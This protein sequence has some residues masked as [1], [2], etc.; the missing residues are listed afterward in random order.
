[1]GIGLLVVPQ[2]FSEHLPT[3]GGDTEAWVALADGVSPAEAEAA[4]DTVLRRHPDSEAV[5][6][7]EAVRHVGS[8]T[9]RRSEMEIALLVLTALVAVT[10]AANGTLLGA[11]DRRREHALLRAVGASRRQLGAS[12]CGEMVVAGAI[13]VGAAVALATVA[14][15]TLLAADPEIGVHRTPVAGTAAAVLVALAIVVL[16]SLWPAR[17]AARRSVVDGLTDEGTALD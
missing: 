12:L 10:G 1:M 7:A 6:V 9:S 5:P 8:W 14:A 16:S 15:H 13:A 11:L 2:V 4:F 3:Y 17:W